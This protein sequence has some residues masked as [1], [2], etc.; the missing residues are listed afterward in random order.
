MNFSPIKG[1]RSKS[2]YGS[3]SNPLVWC[4]YCLS[5]VD[6]KHYLYHTEPD[7]EGLA[8]LERTVIRDELEERWTHS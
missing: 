5:P 4:D 6:R 1:G 7:Y 3:K 2:N 8:E